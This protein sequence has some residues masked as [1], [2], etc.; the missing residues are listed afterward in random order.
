[1]SGHTPGPWAFRTDLK[2]G[3]CGLVATGTGVFAEAFADVRHAGENARAE[4]LANAHL[5]AAAPDLQEQLALARDLLVTQM[6]MMRV[7]GQDVE[8]SPLIAEIDAAL[9]KSRGQS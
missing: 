4:A 6:R 7:F 3:D 8:G 5:I 2:T 1:M 9:A